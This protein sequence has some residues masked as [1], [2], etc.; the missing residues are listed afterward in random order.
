M[1]ARRGGV[2]R[3]RT[4]RRNE[5]TGEGDSEGSLFPV[6]VAPIRFANEREPGLFD[7]PSEEVS[8]EDDSRQELTGLV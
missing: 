1:L 3:W 6:V 7:N 5:E 2:H 8:E 4:K